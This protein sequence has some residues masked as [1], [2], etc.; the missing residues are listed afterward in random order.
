MKR[1]AETPARILG[2]YRAG[3]IVPTNR[4][5]KAEWTVPAGA[6]GGAVA[7]EIVL[8]EPLPSTGHGLKPARVIERL[9]RM[10]DAR[11]VSLI[12]IHT[13]DIRTEFA[14]EALAEARRARG[15]AARGREDL[16]ALPL[17]TI[18]GADARDFDDA[19]FAEPAEGGF[20][21]VVAIADV[22]HYVRPGA[23]LDHEARTRGNSCYFPDRVV[24]M[25]PEALSNDWCSLR[26]GEDRGC[27]FAEIRI[28]AEGRRQGYRFG[29]GIMRSA[30]RLTYEAVQEA[31]DAATPG[32]LPI[33]DLYAAFRALLHARR[34]RGTLELDLP[35][36][37]V[38]LDDAGRVAAVMPRP[39]L[40]SHRLI[41][42]F[43]VLANICA[44]EELER[45]RQPCI[46]RVH[47]PPSDEKLAG[48]RDFLRGFDIVA[49]GRARPAPARPRPRAAPRR[50]HRARRAGQRGDAAQPEP[51]RLQPG[52]YRP[53]RPRPAPLCAFHE[54]D[55]ALCRPARASRADPRPRS[56]CRRRCPTTRWGISRPTP[57]TSPR[58]SAARRWPSATRSTAISPP[59]WRTRSV[60]Y[61]LPAFPA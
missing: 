25:L 20:R 14:P 8:A 12:A 47:A 43:M 46:Y 35:E 39:R 54:P 1:L 49:A 36:R 10:G 60:R 42:E 48:L 13:H 57:S 11:S 6:E 3:R 2:V 9:G 18:D 51:G 15:V 38:V 26:P 34:A 50:R 7:G 21:L 27:L 31:H 40:D 53:F 29:R 17:V 44:A 23:A 61:S 30:A 19:V 59:S 24:P 28:D 55:P 5:A 58:P 37:Q 16:R 33:A 56:R 45:L 22:A 32:A 4:R 52:Q 41:E